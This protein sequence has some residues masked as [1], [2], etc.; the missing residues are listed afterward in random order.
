M[1]RDGGFDARLLLV[2]DFLLTMGDQSKKRCWA[3]CIGGCDNSQS[4]EHLVSASLFNEG[5]IRVE[6]FPWCK[7]TATE[8]GLSSLTAK[9]LC[10]AHNSGL[11]PVDDAGAKAFDAFRKIIQISNTRQKL[12]PQ[13]W[14]VLKYR[15]DGRMLERW[16]LKT[17]INL[18]LGGQYPIGR[19]STKAGEPSEGLVR[20]AYGLS[21]FEGR[22]GLFSIARLGM[23]LSP[24]DNLSFGPL[25]KDR[26]VIEGGL[27]S[28]YGFYYLLF[29]EPQG[30]PHNLKGVKFMG[31]DLG[32][33]HLN[34][35]ISRI[36]V[37]E[38]K[39]RSQVLLTDWAE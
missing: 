30:P 2:V 20:I 29:L 10:K 31:E 26:Q 28:F 27:F 24:R 5:K 22:A 19:G 4:R 38:G 25:I 15:L 12:K 33:S 36:N 13:R 7:G 18:S 11:S 14:K 37:N 34:F 6:G 35:H 16:F 17:L 9:I 1:R 32:Q 23:K 8:I 3:K 21:H 39:Y